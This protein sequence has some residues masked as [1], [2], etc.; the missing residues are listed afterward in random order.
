MEEN[1]EEI[2]SRLA[3]LQSQWSPNRVLTRDNLVPTNSSF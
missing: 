2:R 3:S 1:Y